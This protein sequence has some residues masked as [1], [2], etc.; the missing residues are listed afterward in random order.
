MRALQIFFLLIFER[1]ISN[2]GYYSESTQGNKSGGYIGRS[3]VIPRVIYD[4]STLEKLSVGN[5]SLRN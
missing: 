5:F 3:G 1:L 4:E 2:T